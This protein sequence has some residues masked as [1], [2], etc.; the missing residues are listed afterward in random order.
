MH[1]LDFRNFVCYIPLGRHEDLSKTLFLKVLL[2]FPKISL[3]AFLKKNLYSLFN[4]HYE[5][6]KK[7]RAFQSIVDGSLFIPCI[8]NVMADL[9]H[10]WALVT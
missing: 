8:I 10:S 1:V 6:P 4:I 5:I 3:H 2:S 7:P 9:K